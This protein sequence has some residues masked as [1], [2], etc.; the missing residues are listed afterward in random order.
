MV[1]Q[2]LIFVLVKAHDRNWIS[3][4]WLLSVWCHFNP[5]LPSPPPAQPS[6][7]H[8]H[9]NICYL[10]LKSNSLPP[11]SHTHT[12]QYFLSASQKLFRWFCQA[13]SVFLFCFFSSFFFSVTHHHLL[14]SLISTFKNS[15]NSRFSYAWY[16]CLSFRVYQWVW[17][18]QVLPVK[19]L[20]TFVTSSSWTSRSL[21]LL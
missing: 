19:R 16:H 1:I 5:H 13:F 8:I 6:H 21:S 4:F 17:T 14:P 18:W 9:I 2:A 20:T 7:T 12:H 15:V 11:P 10:H 3:L